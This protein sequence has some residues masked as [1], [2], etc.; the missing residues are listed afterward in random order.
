MVER[1]EWGGRKEGGRKQGK[2]EKKE[3]RERRRK[4]EGRE[5]NGEREGET[6]ERKLDLGLFPLAILGIQ[7]LPL[8]Q[9]RVWEDGSVGK[10]ACSYP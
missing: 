4:K 7:K 3:G 2:D 9:A 8:N 1:D 5:G 6:K 10:S